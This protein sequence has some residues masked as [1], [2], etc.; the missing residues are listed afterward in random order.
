MACER[1][2]TVVAVCYCSLSV[3]LLFAVLVASTMFFPVC[4]RTEHTGP[5]L[6]LMVLDRISYEKYHSNDFKVRSSIFSVRSTI[7][8][9]RLLIS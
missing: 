9:L 8:V 5:F 6:D 2:G 4:E 1:D 7:F 3:M